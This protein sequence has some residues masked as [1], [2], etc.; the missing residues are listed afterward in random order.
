[1]LRI[2]APN[3]VAEMHAG[4]QKFFHRN[5]NQT[6]ISF[7][8]NWF[9]VL[10]IT[11]GPF[12]EG[13]PI[14]V[15]AM[16]LEISEFGLRISNFYFSNMQPAYQHSIKF[17][18]RNSNSEIHYRFENWKRLRAPFCPYFFRSLIRGSRV[19]RPACFSAGRR[20]ALYSSNARVMP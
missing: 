12:R 20:S 8:V 1:H 11:T 14:R 3:L 6:L 10:T 9:N 18:I 19:I 2:P 5:R 17:E 16:D 7:A 13:Q 15:M 4:F